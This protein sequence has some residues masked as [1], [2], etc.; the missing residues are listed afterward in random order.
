VTRT[1]PPDP[2]P[3][4]QP[5][6]ELASRTRTSFSRGSRGDL[7]LAKVDAAHQAW[8]SR[9]LPFSRTRRCRVIPTH[10]PTRV[11]RRERRQAGVG[12]LL[13]AKSNPGITTNS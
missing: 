1:G 9:P 6:Q 4:D 5:P 13:I 3:A 12:L 2:L 7:Q 8:P 11:S 10:P